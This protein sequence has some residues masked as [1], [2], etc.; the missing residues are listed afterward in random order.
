MLNKEEFPDRWKKSIIVP[1]HKK[2]DKT[3]HNKYREISYL[4]TS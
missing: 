1:V 2:S 4:A 3:D